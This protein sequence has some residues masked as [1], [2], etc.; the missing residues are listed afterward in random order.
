MGALGGSHCADV[1][2][3]RPQGATAVSAV[4]DAARA[5]RSTVLQPERPG[6]GGFACEAESVR[7]FAG[8][9]PEKAPDETTT[10]TCAASWRT[11]RSGD[12]GLSGRA[13]GLLKK[14]SIVDATIISAPSS[15]KNNARDPEMHRTRKGSQWHFGMKLHIGTDTRGLVHHLEGTAANVHDLTPSGQLLHGEEEQVRTDAGYRGI[16]KRAEHAHREVSWQIAMNPGRRQ[17][18]RRPRRRRRR[19]GCG[20]KRR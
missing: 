18:V 16:G 9:T 11:C 19:P 1:S 14:G 6:D 15:T 4:G 17:T 10:P 5:L 7:R 20:L 13:G 8:A 12:R 2:E 3:G